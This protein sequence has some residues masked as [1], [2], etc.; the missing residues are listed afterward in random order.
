MWRFFLCSFYLDSILGF[1]MTEKKRKH[2]LLVSEI[3]REETA[4]II[5]QLQAQQNSKT[6]CSLCSRAFDLPVKICT[7]GH[8]ACAACYRRWSAKEKYRIVYDKEQLPKLEVKKDK[9]LCILCPHKCG[10]FSMHLAK[11]PADQ[12]IYDLVDHGEERKCHFDGCAVILSGR[13]MCLHEFDC[14][15]Q[16]IDCAVCSAVVLVSGYRQHLT[17]T[18][19]GLLCSLCN[20]NAAPVT[21]TYTALMEHLQLHKNCGEVRKQLFLY[22]EE[23]G[24]IIGSP[25]CGGE[26]T[27]PTRFVPV[28]GSDFVDSLAMLG[29]MKLMV[30]GR[31]RRNDRLA[32]MIPATVLNNLLQ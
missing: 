10:V 14:Q 7:A 15:Y 24:K 17:K 9:D 6:K 21:Y 18:C 19:T 20:F 32:E 8:Y 11:Q 31:R 30:N 5:T 2:E 3:R 22:Y 25:S 1:S 12:L 13:A 27:L 26:M 4:R 29:C 28:D 23:L 16:T